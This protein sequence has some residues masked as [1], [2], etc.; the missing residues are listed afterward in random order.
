M[1]IKEIINVPTKKQIGKPQSAGS[2]GLYLMKN[3]P[4]K[5]YFDKPSYPT[6]KQ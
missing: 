2:R 5:R 1:K 4:G 3:R 6:K